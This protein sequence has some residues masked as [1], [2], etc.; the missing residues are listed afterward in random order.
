MIVDLQQR[1]MT[2][3]RGLWVKHY[4]TW[5]HFRSLVQRLVAA[6]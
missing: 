3:E 1:S 4:G 6:L 2:V 5:Y